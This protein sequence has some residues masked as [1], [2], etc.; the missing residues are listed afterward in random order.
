MEKSKKITE[1]LE[2]LESDRNIYWSDSKYLQA[3]PSILKAYNLPQDMQFSLDPDSIWGTR[4]VLLQ[5]LQALYGV[6]AE[7]RLPYFAGRGWESSI[8]LRNFLFAN[9]HDGPVWAALEKEEDL[10]LLFHEEVRELGALAFFCIS[11][12]L[13]NHK[14]PYVQ[15]HQS[16]MREIVKTKA[17]K[18]GVIEDRGYNTVRNGWVSSY[19]GAGEVQAPDGHTYY[20]EG[21]GPKGTA[22]WLRQ[23]GGVTIKRVNI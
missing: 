15:R 21:Y 23:E 13:L 11:S 1:W 5:L 19:A 12:S 16:A 20:I 18:L 8:T 14:E 4:S 3:V 10:S 22:E 17:L 2:V 6:T 9:M 7:T